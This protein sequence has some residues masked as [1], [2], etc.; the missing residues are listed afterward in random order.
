MKIETVYRAVELKA[1]GIIERASVKESVITG[2]LAIASMTPIGR[3][4][5]ESFIGDRDIGKKAITI[6]A[7]VFA[8]FLIFFRD[9]NL[10]WCNFKLN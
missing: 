3:G 9:Y 2:V 6:V 7:I 10:K 8:L 5:Q 4:Q 1:P